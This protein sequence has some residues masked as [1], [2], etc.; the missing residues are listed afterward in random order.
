MSSRHSHRRVRPASR[1]PSRFRQGEPSEG[2]GGRIVIIEAPPDWTPA[3]EFD[4]PE[5]GRVVDVV[6][7]QVSD[8]CTFIRQHNAAAMDDLRLRWA[9]WTRSVPIIGCEVTLVRL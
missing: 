5:K 1:V 9:A 8:P 4:V 2:L 6:D 7:L 3:T